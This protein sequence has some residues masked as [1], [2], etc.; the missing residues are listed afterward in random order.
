MRSPPTCWRAP[1][2]TRRPASRRPCPTRR[3]WR[4]WATST[5]ARRSTA[6]CS[7]PNARH[8]IGPTDA[9]RRKAGDGDQGRAARRHQ[10]GRLVLARSPPHRRRAWRFPAQFSGLRPR[11][12]AVPDPWLPRQDQAHRAGRALDFLLPGVPALSQGRI[13]S[14][15]RL[16]YLIGKPSRGEIMTYQ[17][18]IVET[19]GKVG[20]IRLNRPEALNALNAA[21]VAELSGAIDGF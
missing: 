10:G 18:L 19:R 13:A 15:P 7:R 8:K 9:A 3:S 14:G 17:N 16:R 21:L 6:P 4:A 2:P 1:A 20:I 12:Q 5:C 11:G